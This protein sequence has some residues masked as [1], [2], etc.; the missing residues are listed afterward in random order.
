M[1]STGCGESQE[2]KRAGQSRRREGHPL[3]CQQEP[4]LVRVA[5]SYL[6]ISVLSHLCLPSAVD[7]GEFFLCTNSVVCFKMKSSRRLFV[8]KASITWYD[9]F[10]GSD[11]S[12]FYLRTVV[13][14][15]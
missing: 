14:N 5:H 8:F 10:L 7:R 12:L 4:H 2:R 11:R 3:P 13:V 6:L 1:H 15:S 9:F